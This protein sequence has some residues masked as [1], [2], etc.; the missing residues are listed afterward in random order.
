MEVGKWRGINCNSYYQ[1]EG[2]LSPGMEVTLTITFRPME[3]NADIRYKNTK[4]KFKKI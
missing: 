1:L 2:F 4:K 3:L